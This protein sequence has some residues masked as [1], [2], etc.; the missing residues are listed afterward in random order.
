MSAIEQLYEPP[1][2]KRAR[3]RRTP[4]NFEVITPERKVRLRLPANCTSLQFLQAVY[5][6]PRLPLELRIE[7]ETAALPYQHPRLVMIA[8]SNLNPTETRLV[9]SGGLP[10]LPGTDTI[11]PGDPPPPAPLRGISPSSPSET[12]V[13]TCVA[14]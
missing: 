1:A 6:H 2:F 5:S 9:I 3:T 10:R 11:M 13:G 4:N 7:A 8:P 12:E 14:S